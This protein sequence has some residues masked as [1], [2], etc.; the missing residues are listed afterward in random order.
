MYT[1]EIEMGLNAWST[2][3]VYLNK[4]HS[5]GGKSF[6]PEKFSPF[7]NFAEHWYTLFSPFLPTRLKNQCVGYKGGKKAKDILYLR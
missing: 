7:S 4:E 1:V 2:G 5:K 3:Q 6:T